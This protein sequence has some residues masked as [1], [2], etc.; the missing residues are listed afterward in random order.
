MSIVPYNSSNEIV[1]HDPNHGIL[2]LHDNQDN[3]L[4]LVST[5]N[6]GQNNKIDLVRSEDRSSGTR[7]GNNTPHNHIKCPSC[8]FAW[9]EHSNIGETS[10]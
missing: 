1:Y 2:V 3:T 7:Y 6:E 8:G 4:Q 5:T 9:S 10:K